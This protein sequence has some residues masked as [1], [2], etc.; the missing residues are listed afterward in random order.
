M[1]PAVSRFRHI[2]IEGAIGVG[3]TTLA[4]RL[5]AHFGAELLLEQAG[6]NPYLGRY[7]DDPTGYAFQTQVF[8]LFQRL[9]QVT[10]LAQPGMFSPAVVSD[11]MFAKDA[12]FA[13]MTLSD[14]EFAL[15]RQMYGQAEARVPQPDLIIWLQAPVFTL[16]SR[17]QQRG[18]AIEQ[19]ID[20]AYLERLVAAYAT[21]FETF[22][23]APVLVVQTEHFHPAGR[24]ADLQRLIGK[25]GTITGPRA[26]LG[27]PDEPRL[28]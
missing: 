12:L 3:K 18:I 27:A 2:A 9:R 15:Y 20:A 24:D 28:T 22:D 6:D 21:Y 4:R 11:F 14:D 17:I 26:F 23:G 1:E 25:I 16:L 13:R 10:A 7:Y 19:R 8:F 5:A